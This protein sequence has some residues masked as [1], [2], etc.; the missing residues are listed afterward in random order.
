[1]SL[2]IY[3]AA[4]AAEAMKTARPK[5]DAACASGALV[6]V[7]ETPKSTRRSWRILE[8]DLAQWHRSGRPTTKERVA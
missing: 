1:M 6:A 5:I 3:T 8:D 4:E 7:D 2:R